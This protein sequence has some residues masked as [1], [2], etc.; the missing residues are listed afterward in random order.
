MKQPTFTEIVIETFRAKRH[1]IK[2]WT[3]VAPKFKRD[4]NGRFAG[5][6]VRKGYIRRTL[7]RT[8]LQTV[9]EMMA[10]NMGKK[11]AL[12]RNLMAKASHL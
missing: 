2:T 5:G 11:N 6:V 9:S 12:M 8:K 10:E 3:R 1:P 7:D 4:A